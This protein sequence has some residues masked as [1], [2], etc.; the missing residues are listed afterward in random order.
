MTIVTRAPVARVAIEED[1]WF[2]SHPDCRWHLT[3]HEV[4]DSTLTVFSPSGAKLTKFT[5]GAAALR[6]PVPL[7]AWF[8]RLLNAAGETQFQGI[9]RATVAGVTLVGIS[10]RRRR[11]Q[12]RHSLT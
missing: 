1:P 3:H 8:N 10:E 4:G 7:A 2:D 5:L 9:A 6:S 11:L 12:R